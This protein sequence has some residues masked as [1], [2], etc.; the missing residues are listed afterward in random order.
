[1]QK[2]ARKDGAKGPGNSIHGDR[3][4]PSS[5]KGHTDMLASLRATQIVMSKPF[6]PAGTDVGAVTIDSS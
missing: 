6:L 4:R 5:R 1:M 3:D 2:N